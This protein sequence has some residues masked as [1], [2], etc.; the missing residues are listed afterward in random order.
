MSKINIFRHLQEVEG[1]AKEDA[2]REHQE[3]RKRKSSQQ[4]SHGHEML[5]F[6]VVLL[7]TTKIEW[8]SSVQQV[9]DH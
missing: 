3:K 6:V 2:T 5:N 4:V 9:Y 8:V 1:A 7:L